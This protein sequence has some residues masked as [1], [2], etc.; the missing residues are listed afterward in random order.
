MKTQYFDLWRIAH[1]V[2]DRRAAVLGSPVIWV[3]G[4]FS[5]VPARLRHVQK[6][7]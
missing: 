5:P 2:H 7:A 3:G 1:A 4:W 6:L